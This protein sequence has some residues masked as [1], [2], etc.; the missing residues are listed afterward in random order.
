MLDLAM[1]RTR[2]RL[3]GFESVYGM[4]GAEF[5]S[6]YERGDIVESLDFIEWA[7]E[8]K[9]FRLLKEQKMALLGGRSS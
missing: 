8:L 3:R 6:R 1:E 7:G 5:E 4:S 9:T 2:K